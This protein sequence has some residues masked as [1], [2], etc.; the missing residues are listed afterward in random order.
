[1]NNYSIAIF[2]SSLRADFDKYSDRDLLIVAD[3]FETLEKLKD[4]YS[5]DD[6]S[7]SYYTYSKLK[8][9][10]D[11][12]SLFIKHLQNESK[13]IVDKKYR[14]NK[15]LNEFNPKIDYKKDIKDCENYFDIIKVIPETNLGFAWFCDSLYVGLRNYLV[16]KNAEVGIFEFSY[17][18]LLN[19]L[20]EQGKINQFDI[21]I[22]REL[23]VV[24][25]S[26]REEILDELP[27][28]SFIQTLIPIVKTI[29]IIETVK[30]VDSLTFQN[31]VDKDIISKKFNPYQRLRLV[32]GYY[33][34]QEL[35]IPKL[36][37]IISNP[38]FYACKM[39]D[40]DFT[41]NLISEIKKRHTTTCIKNSELSAKTKV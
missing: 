12:G 11:N 15:I 16:F 9:L 25:R 29:G 33:C 17:I 19:G 2:G 31:I 1:M 23:R 41:M 18:K 40:N 22:L 26:Y 38:Q 39:K 30:I 6:W 20:K 4:D 28:L 10:S 35:N 14:L 5:K 7:I 21:E 3:D 36:K 27:S 13:I 34:S 8:Y 24:K 37:K 32:E